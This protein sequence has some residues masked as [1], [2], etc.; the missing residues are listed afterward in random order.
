MFARLTLFIL[1]FHIFHPNLKLRRWIWIGGLVNTAF[2]FATSIAQFYYIIPG[3][4]ET[5]I[6]NINLDPNSP[7][8]TVGIV[9]SSF[10][11]L[12]DFYL[13]TLP[14][15]G[16]TQLQMTKERKLGLISIF[17]SGLL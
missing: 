4:E 2:Y 5:W 13:F 6:S 11:M 12:S 10:G 9:A 16:I 15:I 3:P 8:A 17:G 7:H 14:A 1:Y